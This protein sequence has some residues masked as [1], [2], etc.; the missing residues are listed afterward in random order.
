[1]NKSVSEKIIELRKSRGL[2][3]EQLGEK[4]GVS[5]QAV[6]KWEKGESLPDIL[7]LPAL[8]KT[9]GISIDTL[10]EMPAEAEK[11]NV[12]KSFGN[13][14]RNTNIAQALFEAF[15]AS[16]NAPAPD[17]SPC[18]GLQY[19]ISSGFIKA[20]D[21]RGMGYVFF[22]N[23]YFQY[24]FDYNVE[25]ASDFFGLLADKAVLSVLKL[26]DIDSVITKDELAKKLGL[27]PETLESLLFKLM[28]NRV[29]EC[30]YNKEGQYGYQLTNSILPIIIALNG[31]FLFSKIGETID[32]GK[33]SKGVWMSRND[34]DE[35]GNQ[36]IHKNQDC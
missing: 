27:K 30:N 32:L 16:S 28:T 23:K 3:Q 21:P 5:G 25:E 14:A 18:D 24:L 33:R 20:F 6:S 2:T 36:N 13:Y 10:L 15:E 9:L 19:G 12:M 17:G 1:M 11:E 35:S 26:V 34:P 31:F 29:I 22:G 7:T 4:L 8:C